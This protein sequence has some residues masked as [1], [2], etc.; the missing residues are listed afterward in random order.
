MRREGGKICWRSV[1]RGGKRGDHLEKRLPVAGRGDQIP[2]A[3][4]DGRDCATVHVSHECACWSSLE[5]VVWRHMQSSLSSKGHKK[6]S[7]RRGET[8]AS[9]RAVRSGRIMGQ[10]AVP[11]RGRGRSFLSVLTS[12]AT[13]R[14]PPHRPFPCPSDSPPRPCLKHRPCL[15]ICLTIVSFVPN[16]HISESCRINCRCFSDTDPCY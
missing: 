5:K 3:S 8:P 16:S 11:S 10:E 15:A 7:C 2:I 1:S 9:L 13:V 12:S 14:E 4:G 6:R